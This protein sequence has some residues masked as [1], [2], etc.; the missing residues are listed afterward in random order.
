MPY[1]SCR[2]C[3]I[4]HIGSISCHIIPLLINSLRG[5]D[6]H[7]HMHTHTDI[8]KEIIL[9]N[10][11]CVWPT[12]AWF[13]NRITSCPT[14]TMKLI[15]KSLGLWLSFFPKAKSISIFM[16]L[17]N[18]YDIYLCLLNVGFLV[19]NAIRKAHITVLCV[20]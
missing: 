20:L 8:H 15:D 2:T 3:L 13:K 19:I 14:T 11:A 9:K 1:N 12:C 10:Q 16:K 7:R 17:S 5:R 6:T 4:N 18:F